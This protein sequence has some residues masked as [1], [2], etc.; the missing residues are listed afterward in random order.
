MV[1][2]Y[3]YHQIVD[4]DDDDDDDDDDVVGNGETY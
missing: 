3:S 1:I 4:G 2:I